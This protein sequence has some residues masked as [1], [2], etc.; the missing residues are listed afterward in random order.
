MFRRFS[1]LLEKCVVC[2]V[3][4]KAQDTKSKGRVNYMNM[5]AYCRVST[6]TEDQLN[7]LQTQ[8]EF[9]EEYAKKNNYN[10]IK[11]YADEGI[12][13]TR[14]NKREQFKQ[15]IR[16]SKSGTFQLVAVKDISRFA[17]NTLDFIQGIR[18]LKTQDIRC[19][20]VN[21][22]LSS[23]DSEM[24]LVI[25]ASLAQEESANTSK[26]IKFSKKLNAEKGKVPN[27]VYGYDKIIGDYFNLSINPYEAD[28]VRR[29]Y[30]MYTEDGYGANKISKILN[31]EGITTKRGCSWT[32]N[33]VSRILTNQLY[34]GRIINCKEEI[35]DFLTGVRTSVDEENWLITDRPDLA[36]VDAMTFEKA[37][38]ML[39]KNKDTFNITGR[40]NSSKHIFSTLLHCTDCGYSFRR[41]ERTYKN[42]YVTWGCSGRNAKGAESCHNTTSLDEVEL[43]ESI[44]SYLEKLVVDKKATI[45]KVVADFKKNYK[46]NDENS[47]TEKELQNEMKLL[48]KKRQKYMD[49][50][51][52]EIISMAELKL[53]TADINRDIGK[54]EDK[55]KIVQYNLS[56]GSQLSN[57]LNETFTSIEEI[58][59]TE[60]ITNEMLKKVID[61]IDVSEGGKVDIYFKLYKD[62]GLDETFLFNSDRT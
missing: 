6:D 52:N 3:L 37:Q 61:R 10:L 5:V 32:Q 22:N 31:S 23:M 8:R 35:K 51:E 24:I 17:R 40:R 12:T 14:L 11:V 41:F 18:Y 15:L 39:K 7:S 21:T 9:F 42:T 38:K 45:K 1:R 28:V 47:K 59:K 16:D 33:G 48:K 43:L 49:M 60:D 20:F 44:R 4:H 36:I 54:C 27:L 58:L 53:Q 55:L 13:G 30:K 25:M 29:I 19:E 26:R 2:C 56:Q 34:I 50:Y 62:I 46:S 57:N